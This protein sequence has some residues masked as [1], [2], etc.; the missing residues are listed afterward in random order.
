MNLDAALPHRI[1]EEGDMWGWWRRFQ[2]G[3]TWGGGADRVSRQGLAKALRRERQ[4]RLRIYGA[5]TMVIPSDWVASEA[6]WSVTRP[7]YAKPVGQ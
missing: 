2:K 5:T 4:E 1:R 3:L 7:S 6:S